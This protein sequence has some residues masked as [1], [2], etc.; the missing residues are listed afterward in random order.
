MSEDKGEILPLLLQM[1]ASCQIVSLD[2]GS[3]F[4]IKKK[5][6]A[7]KKAEQEFRLAKTIFTC[8][9]ITNFTTPYYMSP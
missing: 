2:A 5:K 8:K 7:I 6:F 1:G 9:S 4:A 3:T